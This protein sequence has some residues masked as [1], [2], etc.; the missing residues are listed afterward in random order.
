[1]KKVWQLI[2]QELHK[3]T[4]LAVIVSCPLSVL[5][6][7]DQSYMLTDLVSHFRLQYAS[8]G[9]LGLIFA[10]VLRAKYFFLGSFVAVAFNVPFLLPY[11]SSG[12]A[13]EQAT[14]A[15][16]KISVALANIKT[17]N[18]DYDSFTTLLSICIYAGV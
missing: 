14:S 6:A 7:F 16:R 18:T 1:M 12:T 11:M 9:L 5:I 10:T 13:A 4:L 17:E 8:F 15:S 3:W 2:W